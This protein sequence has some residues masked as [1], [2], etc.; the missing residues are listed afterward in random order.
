MEF[1]RRHE[2]VWFGT[3]TY[4]DAIHPEAADKQFRLWSRFLDT[5][6]RVPRTCKRESPRRCIWVRGLEWQ[7]RDVLHYHALIGNVPA[8]GS[9][10]EARKLAELD[11]LTIADGFARIDQ[12]YS[13]EA[14]AYVT[15]YAAKG[16]EVDFS[17]NLSPPDLLSGPATA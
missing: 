9:G 16:G 11:W 8:F 4:K 2:W 3:F 10:L 5:R 7:R 1:L 15:K 13:V 12:C 17:A 6:H 14:L